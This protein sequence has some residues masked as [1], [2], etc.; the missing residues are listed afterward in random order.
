MFVLNCII[1]YSL[2]YYA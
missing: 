2:G 1:V